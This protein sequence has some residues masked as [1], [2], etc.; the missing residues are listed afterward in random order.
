M[1]GKQKGMREVGRVVQSVGMR[2]GWWAGV[3]WSRGSVLGIIAGRHTWG[4]ARR[5]ASPQAITLRPFR[6]A[7]WGC[8]GGKRSGMSA[9]PAG[10]GGGET[11]F[12]ELTGL[13]NKMGT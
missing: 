13:R 4:F 8:L 11:G 12:T 2:T 1:W 3:V 9:V 7:E 6:P 5:L 10:I